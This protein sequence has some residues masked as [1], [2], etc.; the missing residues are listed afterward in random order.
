MLTL[1]VDGRLPLLG[2]LKGKA[3]ASPRSAD[4]P[5]VEYTALGHAIANDELPKI[6]HYYPQVE[7]WKLCIMPVIQSF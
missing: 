2:E 1:V 4:A 6:S 5:R 3:E 7:V